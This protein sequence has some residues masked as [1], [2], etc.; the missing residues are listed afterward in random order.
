M[1]VVQV[2]SSLVQMQVESS[3]VV[4]PERSKLQEQMLLQLKR[5]TQLCKIIGKYVETLNI[6]L[7]MCKCMKS[8]RL[9]NTIELT[10]AYFLSIHHLHAK[11]FALE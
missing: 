2:E 4:V 6:Y 11:T 5:K 1:V 3:L 8:H 10:M 7:N 9:K